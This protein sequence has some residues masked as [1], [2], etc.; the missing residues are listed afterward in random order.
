METDDDTLFKISLA[1]ISENLDTYSDEIPDYLIDYWMLKDF[2][3]NNIEGVP[4]FTIFTYALIEHNSKKGNEEFE[5]QIEDFFG[6]FEQ[7]QTLL[8]AVN[9][10]FQTNAVF[11]PFKLFD[12]SDYDNP[13]L[14][15]L[16]I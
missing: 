15:L 7:W 3:M 13:D 2:D 12:F 1:F 4:Q 14:E 10:E 5:M 6:L 11:K 9:L 16:E 8:V